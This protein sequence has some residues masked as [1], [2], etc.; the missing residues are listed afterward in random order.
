MIKHGKAFSSFAVNDVRKAKDFY[1]R[2][3]G[4]DTNESD[5]MLT[6]ELGDGSNVLVY[7]K[8]DHEPASFTILNLPVDDVDRAI[9]DL[10]TQG[11]HFEIYHGN[12]VETDDRG[13]HLGEGPRIAW[14]KDPA[15]NILSVIE[16]EGP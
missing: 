8:E 13:V 11:V 14:F 15:G 6:L 3:L 5:G 4:I 1:A 7:P 16:E 12:G 9:D 10:T 2:V